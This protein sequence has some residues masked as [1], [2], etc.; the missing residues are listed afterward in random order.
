M[1][2]ALWDVPSSWAWTKISDLGQVVA[3]G[4]PSTKEPKFWGQDVVW[5]S[6]ADLTG[7]SAKLIRRGAKGLSALGLRNSSARVMPAGSVMFSSRAPIGYVAINAVDAATNQGFKSVVPSAAVFNE[8][9]YYFLKASKQLAEERATGT[10]F[11]EIS[12]SAFAVLPVPL[13][14]LPE[15]HRIV[16]KIEAL[17]SELDKAV[18]SLTLARAQLK[19][20]RQALLKHAFEGKLTADWR[21]AN[22]DKLETPDA[23]L[24]RIRTEREARY[25]RAFDAWQTA[26]A[27]WRAGGEVGRKPRRPHRPDDPEKIEADELSNLP[28]LA[29]GWAYCR[30]A[31]FVDHI[32]AG[33][34]FACDEREPRQDEIGVAKVSAVSW[35][36]YNEAESKTCKDPD[37]EDP[38]LFIREGDFLL[39]RANTIELVGACVIVRRVSKR[40]MLSDKTLR[41][42]F[43]A[44]SPPYFLHYLRSIT[45]RGEIERRSTGNQESMR[46]IGQDRIRN[47]IVPLCGDDEGSQVLELLDQRLNGLTRIETEIFV[48]LAKANALRQSILKQAFSGQLVAQDPADES[49]S[50]LLARLRGTAHVPKTRRK[51]TE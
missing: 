45:G 15:Q 20:Y 39:S 19:T 37:R 50:I 27:E 12:G 6:P 11:K 5:F 21:A 31:E 23:L 43:G 42:S 35:G 1:T 49:A 48:A 14:P 17:F 2:E 4:T 46:N 32:A 18:E 51:R 28:A 8:Y 44:G 47:I 13:A 16:A 22:A 3:G 10:T 9:L 36:E 26:L 7:Y 25:A 38:D 33:N 40:V 30:L 29:D 34:S 41:I 24:S